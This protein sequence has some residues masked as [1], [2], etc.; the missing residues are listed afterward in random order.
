MAILFVI[1]KNWKPKC[2]QQVNGEESCD[3]K[4]TMEYY[5]TEKRKTIDICNICN[6]D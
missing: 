2:H 5:S 6:K 1:A 3:I 4:N